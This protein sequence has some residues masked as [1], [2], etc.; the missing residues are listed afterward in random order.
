MENDLKKVF[1]GLPGYISLYIMI[2]MTCFPVLLAYSVLGMEDKANGLFAWV[3][4]FVDELIGI[5]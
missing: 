4:P 2:I 1:L 5:E 3:Q